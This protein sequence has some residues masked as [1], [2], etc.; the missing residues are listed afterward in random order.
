[1][2]R[3][4]DANRKVSGVNGGLILQQFRR[5]VTGAGFLL[6]LLFCGEALAQT[7]NGTIAGTVVDATGAGVPQATVT[8]HGIRTGVERKTKT[9]G[10]GGFRLESVLLDTYTVTVE[11]PGF[12][13]RRITDVLVHASI[14]TAVNPV[15][16]AGKVTETVQVE[17]ASELLQTET[18]EISAT[19]GNDAIE[20]LPIDSLSPYELAVTLPGVS[21]PPSAFIGAGF[22]N[23]FQFSVNGARPRANNF[24][25]EGQDNNDLGL[26][27]PAI[28][29]E[30]L[31]AYQDVIFLLNAYQAEF[32]HGG[33]SVSN[34]ILRS[35]TNQFHGAVYER[36]ENSSLDAL[37]KGDLLNGSTQKS[38]YRE[39]IAGFSVG[40]PV[41]KE[42]LFFFVSYQFDH[43]RS[44][45]NLNTLI[46]PTSAGVSTLQ[47]LP[48]NPR[49][50]EYL[51][52]I[53]SL[54][55]Q[56]NTVQ[57]TNIA[58][59]TAPG[60]TVDRGNMQVG[61]Y[62][63]NLNNATDSSELDIK[64]DYILSSQDRLQVHYVRAPSLEPYNTTAALLPGFD[65]ET[66]G[67]SY[68]AGIVETHIFTTNLLN[69]FR[70]SYGR[71]G[72]VF[73]LR[74]ETYANPLGTAPTT[75]VAGVTGYGAPSGYPQSRV[76]N[77]YQIQDSVSWIKGKHSIKVGFD[78]PIIQ[79]RD[80]IPF[81]IYGSLTYSSSVVSV[82]A[83][84][85]TPSHLVNY[86]AFGNYIDDYGG[87][88][89][90]G[91]AVNQ[92]FGNSITRPMFYFQNYFAQDTWK[93][94]P[95]LSLDFGL[96]YEYPGAA[97]NNVKYLGVTPDT[98]SN[99]SAAVPQQPD[100]K[101]W[102]PRFGFAY[103][104][105]FLGD[106]KTVLRGG[107]GIFYDGLFTDIQDTLL[108]FAPN[109]ATPSLA[110]NLSTARPR[111]LA[112]ISTLLPTLSHTASAGDPAYYITPHML[113]PE[114][115]Q[116][117]VNVERELPG[118]FTAQ[119]GYVGTRGEHLYATTEFNP[120]VNGT[121]NRLFNTRGRV[122]RADNTGDS[123]YHA[124]QAGAVRKY[125]NG[126]QF[127]AAYTYSRAEDDTSE[128]FSTGGYST[129]P[130]VQ[131]PSAR[132]TTD[133]GLSA[134]DHRQR[135]VLSYVYELPKWGTAPRVLGEVVNGWQVSGITQFQSGSPGNVE[136][137]FDWNADGIANDRPEIANANAPVATYA[138]HGD[139]PNLF[140][141]GPGT[142]CDGAYAANT[143]DNCHP[144]AAGS[145]HWLLPYYGTVGNPVGR[146]SFLTRGFNQWDFSAQKSFKT[147]KEQ[148][149]DVRAE[150]FDIFNH[151]NTGVPNL[152]L[153][154]GIPA[155]VPPSSAAFGNYPI[156][157]TGHRSIRFYFRYAF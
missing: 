2:R 56:L 52:A 18:G 90:A 99:F 19:V 68:N 106:K 152:N 83:S 48:A 11:A 51:Q 3:L 88:S 147:W 72:D 60:S 132:K 76:H 155:G 30:N 46:L 141:L 154:T 63:R 79:V 29:G 78:L 35:G 15:L 32:G 61:P 5:I 121:T 127:R 20:N 149:F 27:G 96:R 109:A 123:N 55:G 13:Q 69:E 67:T 136:I 36:L 107:F 1:L 134:F 70:F 151:G 10:V 101:D 142:Y 87:Q 148:S 93:V 44:T 40:G 120:Y 41:L 92:N 14:V 91:G 143:S 28:P 8:A 75:T 59:G 145:F 7:S 114:S 115:L 131:Y 116:W 25:I 139:D 43:Y 135:L 95:D 111:G 146:N 23:G 124:L 126:F 104:P 112:S 4:S 133:Y 49:I 137:G 22:P 47:A 82:P 150:M 125:R 80:Q 85:G 144:V 119:V 65:T 130:I 117:N 57:T 98:V 64:S 89:P 74:P 6:F 81:N 77:T 38:K 62:R 66:E 50:A 138:V 100:T 94:S 45:A 31:E 110:S 33:G 9:N 12:S 37:D 102:S 105:A 157:V 16:V 73:D 153:G 42:K 156:T 26:H 24:L 129:F 21:A 118:G 113:S 108:A 86:S 97:F 122:I 128:I 39:N 17:A 34:L 53:G 103:T 140:G 58:L 54:R 71:I 84:G